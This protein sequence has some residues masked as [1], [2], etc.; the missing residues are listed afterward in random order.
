MI[1]KLFGGDEAVQVFYWPWRSCENFRFSVREW[2]S[3]DQAKGRRVDFVPFR[4]DEQ[5]EV[6]A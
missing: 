6:A 1:P 5:S 2:V 4:A 3:Q